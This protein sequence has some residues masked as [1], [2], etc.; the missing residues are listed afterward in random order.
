MSL[1]RW[2][3]PTCLAALSLAACISTPSP[4]PV[5]APAGDVAA[6]AGEW[7]GEYSGAS[8]RSGSI[9]FN[10]Q[11]GHDTAY[12]DVSMVPTA[13]EPVLPAET[14]QP[15]AVTRPGSRPLSIRFVRITGDSV[16]GWLEPYQAP[17]CNCVLTTTF[18]GRASGD[19]IEGTF[20]TVGDPRAADAQSG[21]WSVTRRK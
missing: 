17:D 21:K 15:G 10:L 2:F 11:A 9:V 14:G 18:A 6:L 12:G 3:T 4:V 5:I 20:R 8:G 13:G 16:S 7:R 1:V 19:R